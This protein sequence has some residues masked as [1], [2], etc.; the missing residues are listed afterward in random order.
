VVRY[1]YERP[2]FIKP[3]I[4]QLDPS[5]LNFTSLVSAQQRVQRPKKCL[6]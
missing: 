2:G 5:R 4:G 6:G 3:P 1:I